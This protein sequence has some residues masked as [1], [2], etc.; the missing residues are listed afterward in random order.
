MGL[1]SRLQIDFYTCPDVNFTN[2][3]GSDAPPLIKGECL[4]M[5]R[6]R[7]RPQEGRPFTMISRTLYE[8]E[9]NYATHEKELLAIFWALAKLRNYL[10]AAKEIKILHQP[11]TLDVCG[12][13]IQSERQ[14]QEVESTHRWVRRTNVLQARK[15]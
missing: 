8:R 12:I 4:K 9:V 14:D 6:N 15:K 5:L 3:D 1:R 11:P 13:G 10:Y 7:K 2:V